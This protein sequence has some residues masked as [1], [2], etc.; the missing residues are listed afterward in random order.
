MY[1]QWRRKGGS[2][3]AHAPLRSPLSAATECTPTYGPSTVV[4]SQTQGTRPVAVGF[5]G[6]AL[7][8]TEP[9]QL[10]VTHSHALTTISSSGINSVLGYSDESLS[11][12]AAVP[13]LNWPH[14][15]LPS[16]GQVL[17]V[18][19]HLPASTQISTALQSHTHRHSV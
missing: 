4:D 9:I 16:A 10:N 12:L 19:R 5:E 13:S 11:L 3:G 14:Q 18:D 7:N 8:L 15:L 1:T 6:L 2:E 17:P